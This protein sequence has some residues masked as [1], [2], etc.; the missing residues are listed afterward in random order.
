M[1]T[2][3]QRRREDNGE[4]FDPLGYRIIAANVRELLEGAPG[5]LSWC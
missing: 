4:S 5:Q 1:P 3:G 2:T